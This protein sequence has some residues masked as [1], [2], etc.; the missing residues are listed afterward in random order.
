MSFT[1]DKDCYGP[2]D[3]AAEPERL[4]A[5]E[6]GVPDSFV[7]VP[8]LECVMDELAVLAHGADH[9]MIVHKEQYFLVWRLTLDERSDGPEVKGPIT[10]REFAS[11]FNRRSVVT[12]RKTQEALEH[13]DA[14]D[15]A[16]LDHGLCPGGAVR[17]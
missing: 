13:P 5:A 4:I 12:A 8:E 7:G 9:G 15:A 10:K 2:D 1:R 3:L 11:L 17:A 14:F 6:A 16:S